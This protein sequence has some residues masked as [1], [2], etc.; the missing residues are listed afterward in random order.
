MDKPLTTD[1]KKVIVYIDGYNFYYGMRDNNWKKYYWLDIV[2]FCEKFIGPNQDLIKVKYF[3]AVTKHEQKGRRQ[4]RFFSANKLNP[5]FELILGSYL[6]KDITCHNC[7]ITFPVPEEKKTD[8]NIATNLISDC[9]YNNCNISI[10]ISGDS[11]LT[12]PIEF[13]KRHNPDHVIS[14][15]FPP[16]RVG[17]HLKQIAHNTISLEQYKNRFK[18]S[19]LPDIIELPSGYKLMRP[20][21]WR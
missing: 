2:A 13:I 14:V 15:F 18:S 6:N 4:D 8:V 7:D 5:R 10:L 3:S 20:E 11:D 9:I 19:L 17:H 16:K 12:P 1:R 21:K